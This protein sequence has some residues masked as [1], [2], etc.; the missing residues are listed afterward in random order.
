MGLQDQGL[1]AATAAEGP[2]EGAVSLDDPRVE[3]GWNPIKGI[4][5]AALEARTRGSW[6]G[7][8]LSRTPQPPAVR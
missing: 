5:V 2:N 7:L 3:E 4:H 8:P 1:V 6:Q